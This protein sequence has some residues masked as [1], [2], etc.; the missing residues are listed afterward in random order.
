MHSLPPHCLHQENGSLA[1]S[2]NFLGEKRI[3]KVR[4][5]P[6]VGCLVSQAQRDELALEGND[7]DL[8]SNSAASKQQAT[9]ISNKDVRAC[10]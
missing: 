6:G 10:G 8:A 1:E 5:R 2:Q 3:C 7:I 9:V 4:L